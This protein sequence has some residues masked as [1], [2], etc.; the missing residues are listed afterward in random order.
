MASRAEANTTT[1]HEEIQRWAEERG[2]QPAC[3]KGTGG[4][5]DVGMLRLDF[6]GYSGEESL[7]H[8]SWDDWFEKFD[9][10][11]LA[12]LYQEQTAG[13]A[14]SNFNKLVSR[15]TAEASG[16]GGKSRSRSKRPSGGS[17]KAPAKKAP[18]KKAPAKKAAGKK[19]A[20]KK[21]AKSAGKRNG[22][23]AASKSASK[24]SVSSASKRA[25]AKKTS[26]R[27]GAT[28]KSA[29]SRGGTSRGKSARSR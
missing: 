24:K 3:V 1:N 29:G 23:A 16:R 17:K 6:P 10:R 14:Q 27:G 5:G 13:G 15:E 2:G 18:P 11:G 4:E 21:A 25:A 8:I 7:Q 19:V 12:L 26:S 9:E 22:G 20:G 28:K